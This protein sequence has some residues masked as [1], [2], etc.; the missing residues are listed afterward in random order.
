MNVLAAK[1]ERM[2]AVRPV[3]ILKGLQEVLWAAERNAAP[4]AGGQ[5]SWESEKLTECP[6]HACV[7]KIQ[8][9]THG[10]LTERL[11]TISQTI[12]DHLALGN[13]IW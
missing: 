1:S 6:K 4:G 8:R 11:V 10:L 3:H 7:G 12:E 9:R 5:V 2:G 13:Q